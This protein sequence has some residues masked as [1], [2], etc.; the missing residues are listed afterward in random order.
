MTYKTDRTWKLRRKGIV[1][2]SAYYLFILFF[3][4]ANTCG[5]QKFLNIIIK[6][7]LIKNKT[8]R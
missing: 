5:V 2:L 3:C 4:S 8:L 6:F 7:L 1:L